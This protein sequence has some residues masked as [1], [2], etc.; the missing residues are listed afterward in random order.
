M[1]KIYKK[2]T[3]SALLLGSFS[4][5]NVPAALLQPLARDGEIFNSAGGSEIKSRDVALFGAADV[6]KQY[7]R[8]K[9]QD[10]NKILAEQ[11][12]LAT[13]QIREGIESDAADIKNGKKIDI[14]T[15]RGP[16]AKRTIRRSQSIHLSLV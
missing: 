4:L 15:T 1:M 10:K 3:L 2:H 5:I 11:L 6:R 12:A 9:K 8:I 14:E 13:G 7:S 16:P